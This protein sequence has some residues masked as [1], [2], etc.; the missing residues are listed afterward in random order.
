MATASANPHLRGIAIA[1]A[2]AVAAVGLGMMT[3]SRQQPSSS[4]ATGDVVTHHVPAIATPAKA[5]PA[6]RPAP[7]V[8][9]P[10]ISKPS[11]IDSIFAKAALA[12]GL[13][14]SLALAFADHE[15]AVVTLYSPDSDVDQIAVAESHAGAALAGAGYVLVNASSDTATA[16]LTKAF[17]VLSAPTTLVLRRSDFATP[18]ASLDGFADRETVAQ[19]AIN[20]DPTPGAPVQQ[21]RWAR[22][23]DALCATSATRIA[24]VDA[25]SPD[26]R[27]I[28]DALTARLEKLPPPPARAADA[29]QLVALLRQDVDV[30]LQLAS[31]KAAKDVV[32]AATATAAKAPLSAR[33]GQLAIDLGA[34][35]C[36]QLV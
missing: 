20:A 30:S 2:L 3:L 14:K 13:P 33:L 31:A 35:S 10:K 18:F 12:A 17:G 24:R 23:A 5:K 15:V 7:K 11:P 32:G 16:P 21:S 26:V 22:R 19:A 36:A 28:S 8:S 6:A 1:G 34:P 29:T 25:A 27:T 9:K 4:A